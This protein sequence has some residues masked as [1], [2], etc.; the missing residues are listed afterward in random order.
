MPCQVKR[1]VP[2]I[3]VS[4]QNS[5]PIRRPWRWDKRCKLLFFLAFL[6]FIVTGQIRID[7]KRSGR[8]RGGSGKVLKSGFEQGT[9]V[10][11]QRCMSASP[12]CRFI[13]NV[14]KCR[15]FRCKDAFYV[16]SPFRLFWTCATVGNS[17]GAH[18]GEMGSTVACNI[19]LHLRFHSTL[20]PSH[21][22]AEN[23]E[24]SCNIYKNIS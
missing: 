15:T 12:V 23:E 3:N 24:T 9:P 18:V 22:E 14:Q 20:C 11:Q 8:E 6:A 17:S 10:A 13:L 5:E 1:I 7:R 19:T 2:L 16:N 21:K 4:L